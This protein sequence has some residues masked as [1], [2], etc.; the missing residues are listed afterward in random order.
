MQVDASWVD[1]PVPEDSVI[2]LDEVHFLRKSP[3][4]A[5]S[6]RFLLK[7]LERGSRVVTAGLF[8]TTEFRPF[9]TTLEVVS[10]AT[11]VSHRIAYCT[12]C[13]EV[14]Q[15]AICK[16]LKEGPILVGDSIYEPRCTRHLP[17]E[18]PNW[19]DD[20]IST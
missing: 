20:A 18:N 1:I 17:T 3:T 4:P 16:V 14:A 19:K 10:W 6:R 13:R 9:E 15:F 8:F 11:S 7:V 5:D 2:L 12:I